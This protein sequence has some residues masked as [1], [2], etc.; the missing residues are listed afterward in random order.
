MKLYTAADYPQRILD[1]LRAFNQ[2]SDPA[3]ITDYLQTTERE[4]YLAGKTVDA[5]DVV[6]QNS[7]IQSY[8]L[9]VSGRSDRT[10]YY[11]SGTYVKD[12]GLIL[13]DNAKRITVRSNISTRITDWMEVGL[14]SQF[15]RRDLSG[16]RPPMDMAYSLSPYAK[17]YQDDANTKLLPFPVVDQLQFN[18]LLA[19]AT[20]K[21]EVIN[22]N[23]LATMY[24][25]INLPVKGLSYRFNY[26]AGYR[27]NH[28]YSLVPIY[29][30]PNT[31]YVNTGSAQKTNEQ[32]E[33]WQYENILTYNKQLGKVHGFD[34]TLL[35]GANST[36][37]ENTRS[38]S[39]NLFNDA[40]GYNNLGI[41]ISQQAV[42]Q[43]NK[44]SGISYMARLNY[45]FNQRY[46]LTLTARRDGSSTFGENH[47]YGTFPSAAVAWILSDEPFIRK[48]LPS[49]SLLKARVSYG[50][51]GNIAGNPYQSLGQFATTQYVFG[52]GSPTYTGVYPNPSYM[53]NPLLGWETTVGSNV[54]LDFQLLRD[55]IGGTVEYYNTKTNDL[56]Q[57]QSVS[58]MTGFSNQYF[59][60]GQTSNKGLE[61][62]L[63]TV[64][65][66][67]GGFE[68]SSNIVFSTNRNRIVH[69]KY[70]D[71]NKDGKEDNDVL[72]GWF[73]GQSIGAVYDYVF[74][75]IYQQGETLP[76]G[77][78]P[79]WIRVKDVTN[80]GKITPDDRTII[81]QRA[82]KYRWGIGNTFK[83]GAF[84]LSFFVN[85][86]Q[87]FINSFN[88]L[89]VSSST[90]GG[91]FP[92]RPVNML[93]AGYWTPE[94]KSNTRPGLNFTNPLSIY[95]YKKRD[96]VRLQDASIDY[97]VPRKVTSKFGLTSLQVYASGRN[98]YTKTEWPGP[99]PESG[100]NGTSDL[101]PTP[102]TIS[103][104]IR[105]S[106]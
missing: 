32:S 19:P 29:N 43:A 68:W 79:G 54:A 99:D 38:T 7:N 49:F 59:N 58:P 69:L 86:M 28:N 77:Y 55:R 1:Y 45:R 66:V 103:F 18:P 4:M 53:P 17:L 106:L 101:Y 60:I 22:S 93:S 11:L 2:P 81:G 80:D 37:L 96:F 87:G 78:K 12:K 23:L 30:T 6:S 35:Q 34:V 62:S 85:S 57:A 94:N 25:V 26:N 41:G 33:S 9:N 92:G 104:G 31:G 42:T 83:Y 91:S 70:Q 72:N 50:S 27:W 74:D 88:M 76:T 73:I 95:Y 102:R 84:S 61:I 20:H 97:N 5:W 64:N 98:L 24:A 63:N 10:S 44:T 15:T 36:K 16:I 75:G 14:N 89:D 82:P 13:N 47:K 48:T 40:N 39:T 3:R 67:K 52:D 71:A 100:S 8:N 56:L 105:A 51:V 21:N 65:L 90:P 46:L